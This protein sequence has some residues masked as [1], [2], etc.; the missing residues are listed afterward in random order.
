MIAILIIITIILILLNVVK[1]TT[2]EIVKCKNR[3]FI[4]QVNKTLLE[5]L[6]NRYEKSVYYTEIPNYDKTK[7]KLN[8]IVVI[9]GVPC[10]IV[11]TSRI[12][13]WEVLNFKEEKV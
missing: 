1:I 2:K 6:L 7:H 12:Q 9:K 3:F 11:N 8:D 13:M 5:K 4:K 10:K